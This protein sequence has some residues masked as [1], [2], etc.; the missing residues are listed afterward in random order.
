MPSPVL[1]HVY[2]W[3][4]PIFEYHDASTIYRYLGSVKPATMPRVPRALIA[5]TALAAALRL[6]DARLAVAVAGRGADRQA[7]ARE[8]RRPVPRVAQQE[9][10][11]PL[12]YLFEWVWTRVAGTSEF[13]LRL[14]SALCGIALVPVAYAIGQA[15]GGGARPR[16][17]WPRSSP[18]TRCSSTTRRRR[19]GTRR[20]RS[21]ARSASSASSR[22]RG[23]PLG[24]GGGVGGR[25]R[26]PLLRDLPDRDRG[27]DPAPRRGRAALP[28]VAGVG[29]VGAAC[30]RSLLE[31][32]G[33]GH[34]DNVTA[35]VGLATRAK[36][37]GDE[38]DGR[39][40]AAPRSTASS[41]SAAR[42]CVAGVVVLAMRGDWRAALL[43]AAVGGGGAALMLL[44][45]LVR[46][47]LPQQPQHDP[48]AGDRARDPGARV[49]AGTA[50]AGSASRPARRC[51]P[52]R[53]AR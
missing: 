6:P 48:G 45:A 11:P 7:R 42:C 4:T 43:P 14:P 38:L 12:F 44:A 50:G 10:N 36:G 8:P 31:Q 52:R 26:L 33:G 41:G 37:V 24:L 49:R 32:I 17:R 22:A 29:V 16:S 1:G 13:A 51:S 9:A 25:A 39:A 3:V 15:A 20:W 28:A 46:R 23:R 47:R 21:R 19:A 30:C 53:S 40:S 35:G 27:G 5:L 34:S 2:A 18:S